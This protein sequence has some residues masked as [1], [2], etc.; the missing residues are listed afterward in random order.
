M[1]TSTDPARRATW[2]QIAVLLASLAVLLSVLVWSVVV[3]GNRV[4]RES[5][6]STA[7]RSRVIR[8]ISFDRP[9]PAEGRYVA[10]PYLGSRVCGECHPA[11]SAL[12]SRSGHAVTLRPA[13][14]VKTSRRLDGTTQADPE[15]PGVIWTYRYENNQ[16][17]ITRKATDLVQQWIADYAIGSGH[18]ALTYVSVIDHN[19]PLVL[20]HRLSYYEREN[21][22]SGLGITQ[23]HDTRPPPPGLMPYGGELPPRIGREC[24][25]CHAT[26]LAAVDDEQRFDEN[27]MIP[28][29]SCERCHGPGKAHVAAARR[30]AP[31]A[32]LTLPFGPGRYTAENLLTLCG[33]CHRLPSASQAGRINPNNP[34][35]V[36]F[37]PV[38][39]SQSRCYQKSAGGFSCVTCHDV[40][41]RTLRDR[42]AYDQACLS[43]HAVPGSPKP[44]GPARRAPPCPVSARSR[45]VECHMPRKDAGQGILFSDHWIR[46]HGNDETK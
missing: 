13:G 25:R 41:A 15:I 11:E 17:Q 16:L 19:V 40:H 29:V 3:S 7:K 12:H 5:K 46:I 43:C 14:R 28:N 4:P 38:G 32:E 33:A 21:G 35:L 36:R 6:T 45:C 1:P 44:E 24:F 42:S 37:Q 23:G 26:Q 9:F 18:H 22:K 20:E 8:L 39:I 10:D 27:S 30:R 34:T 31:E 2:P